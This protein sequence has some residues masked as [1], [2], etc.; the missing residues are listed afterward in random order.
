[1]EHGAEWGNGPD[2]AIVV[3]VDRTQYHR[4]HDF[5]NTRKS[6]R[7]FNAGAVLNNKMENVV[8]VKVITHGHPE[9]LGGNGF[10]Q[11][12]TGVKFRRAKQTANFTGAHFYDG[13]V[14][15]ADA[16]SL[17]LPHRHDET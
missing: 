4:R 11:E 17:Q 3:S 6:S 12:P 8:I 13:S 14:I 7:F 10:L 1:M 5:Y 15:E 2:N 16:S 9:L